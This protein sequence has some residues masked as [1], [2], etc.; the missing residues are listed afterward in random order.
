VP[1]VGATRDMVA[2]VF[3][4]YRATLSEERRVL[5]D[6]HQYVESALKVVG[7]G[8]VGTMC[9]IA[10]MLGETVDAPLFLQIKEAQESVLSPYLKQ[11]KYQHM[12][13]RVVNG[14][15]LMQA[16]T[17]IFLGWSTGPMGRFFYVRQLRD[18]KGSLEPEKDWSW[19]HG[20]AQLCARAL[21]CAHA[22]SVE[23][24]LIGGYLGP[25]GGA[26]PDAV[27]R[28]AVVY[29]DRSAADFELLRQAARDGIVEVVV[30]E[31]R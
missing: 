20:Y 16:S 6:R 22:R 11:S 18:M 2:Q 19:F 31:D 24:A 9:A 5:L 15:R 8:S 7:V 25:D 10:L 1:I 29:A 4:D 12:G 30:E 27:S 26:F 17:D 21:A 3:T 23:P 14:Q 13:H 28:F